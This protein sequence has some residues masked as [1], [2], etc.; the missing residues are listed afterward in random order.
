MTDQPAPKPET[1]E[2]RRDRDE[3][4]Q[5]LIVAHHSLDALG[6]PRPIRT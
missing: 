5:L 1:L 6:V 4:E 3:L 2:H